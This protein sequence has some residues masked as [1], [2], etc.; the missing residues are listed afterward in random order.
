MPKSGEHTI[1]SIAIRYW[2]GSINDIC[3]RIILTTIRLEE[4]QLKIKI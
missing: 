4:K 2:I 1:G 3:V